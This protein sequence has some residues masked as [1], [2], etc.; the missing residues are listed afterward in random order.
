LIEV[1]IQMNNDLII[2]MIIVC[3]TVFAIILAV[4]HSKDEIFPGDAVLQAEHGNL[5]Y[6]TANAAISYKSFMKNKF[7]SVHDLQFFL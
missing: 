7:S 4:V 5:M 1:K 6:T 2:L 3:V